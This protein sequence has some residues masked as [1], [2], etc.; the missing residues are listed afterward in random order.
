MQPLLGFQSVNSYLLQCLFDTFFP[1]DVLISI[2]DYP[3]RL[4]FCV[5][6]LF[7]FLF[8]LLLLYCFCMFLVLYFFLNV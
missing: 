3:V 2:A 6:V 5:T 4:C 1:L 7:S 8:I